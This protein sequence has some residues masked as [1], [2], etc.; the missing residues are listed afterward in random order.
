MSLL[1]FTRFVLITFLLI[2]QNEWGQ[3]TSSL[4]DLKAHLPKP[5]FSM[6]KESN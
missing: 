6:A 2:L 1:V 3:Y 4:V 5:L